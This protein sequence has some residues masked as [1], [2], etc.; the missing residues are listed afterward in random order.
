MSRSFERFFFSRKNINPSNE[1]IIKKQVVPLGG[2]VQYT[3]TRPNDAEAIEKSRTPR[4]DFKATQIWL[5]QKEITNRLSSETM[6]SEKD[7]RD[8]E[9]RKNFLGGWLAILEGEGFLPFTQI[10]DPDAITREITNISNLPEEER[11]VRDEETLEEF[12]NILDIL[13]K[14]DLD[15]PEQKAA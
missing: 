11:D 3:I 7:R 12:F 14:N 2:F 10:H 13:E 9:H 5:E 1:P 15:R 4:S 6:L 8:L